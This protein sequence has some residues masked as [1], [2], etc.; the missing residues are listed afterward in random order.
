M[1]K[2]KYLEDAIHGDIG[3]HHVDSGSIP[4]EVLEQL[5]RRCAGQS[6]VLARGEVTG[7]AH[8][9]T[10]KAPMGYV[11]VSDEIAYALLDKAGLLEH[12]GTV[13]GEGH[14]TREMAPGY[15]AVPTERD[16]DPTC[17]ERR[18]VD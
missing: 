8:V 11:R 14:R 6:V 13:P 1:P 7:H 16:Y 18:V 10:S 12:T 9:L 4:P 3:M 2:D 5:E 15:Y 17:Y